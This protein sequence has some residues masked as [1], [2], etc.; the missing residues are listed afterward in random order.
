MYAMCANHTEFANDRN[1]KGGV[2]LSEANM[3]VLNLR[4]KV[5]SILGGDIYCRG[6]ML[7]LIVSPPFFVLGFRSSIRHSSV[8]A[9]T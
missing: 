7:Q 3:K 1:D 8:R 4:V 5:A 6:V 2:A 9:R